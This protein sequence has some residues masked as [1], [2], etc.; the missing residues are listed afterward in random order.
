MLAAFCG[1][2]PRGVA[3][4]DA[5]D[6]RGEYP[7]RIDADAREGRIMEER[8]VV[9]VVGR[10]RGVVGRPT[11]RPRAV[12][13]AGDSPMAAAVDAEIPS[14]LDEEVRKGTGGLLRLPVVPGEGVREGNVRD[15]RGSTPGV[16][17]AMDFAGVLLT[18]EGCGGAARGE[19]ASFMVPPEIRE[20]GSEG[21]GGWVDIGIG[22]EVDVKFEGRVFDPCI[23]P[24]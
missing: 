4:K 3:L 24:A 15:G 21:R 11:G 19:A 18:T 20:L 10:P 17:G 1:V 14:Q 6:E 5:E 16:R 9:L 22:C 23:V 13:G 12:P 7:P 8:G 2:I